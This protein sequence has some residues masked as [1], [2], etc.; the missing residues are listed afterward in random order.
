M[1]P[2]VP[3]PDWR[4]RPGDPIES[5]E[6]GHAPW[7]DD[8]RRTSVPAA[9]GSR[10]C[11]DSG[12]SGGATSSASRPG[13]RPGPPDGALGAWPADVWLHLDLDAFFA[14]VEEL[15]DPSLRGKPVVVGGRL[16]PDGTAGRGV[17]ST[18]NYAAREFGVGS[19]MPLAEAL[20]R[21]PH[22]VFLRGRFDR[23]REL[24]SRVM[25]VA[26]RF[27]PDMRRAGIDEAYLR[28]TGLRCWT[29]LRCSGDDEAADGRA[30][31]GALARRL[32]R[33]VRE[34][35]GLSCSVGVGPNR[36]L[37]KIASDYRKPGGVTVV[38]AD[39]AADFAS[40]L[41]LRSLRGVGPKSAERLRL[42]GFRTG[43]DLVGA[44]RSVV[45][46]LLGDHGGALW[47]AAHG[48]P[49]AG[50]GAR[51][52]GR[53]SLSHETTFP[54]DVTDRRALERALAR[55]AERAA[56]R[57]RREG[58]RAGC[59]GVKVRDADFTTRQRDR[60]MSD[61]RAGAVGF[62]SDERDIAPVALE[63]FGELLGHAGARTRPI[64]LV[65]VRLSRLSGIG[66]RQLRLGEGEASARADR[67]NAVAD[68]IRA[69]H[70]FDAVT[71]GAAARPV[72]SRP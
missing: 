65:G 33:E 54:E 40:G 64:R 4:T 3:Q 30:W 52:D 38:P 62:T 2:R 20:R 27:T 21:C 35:T 51:D 19:A 50:D 66:G 16:R 26:A 60:S 6:E 46:E 10:A 63:L 72:P 59:V 1:T 68:A 23:Y 45:V 13:A 8:A 36:F 71:S 44:D 70:G 12:A 22:A 49:R 56:W 53:R 57:L 9:A 14:Q 61:P 31:P 15:D 29:G 5:P 43:A 34:A 39:G 67:V 25:E 18:A 11:A 32:Q 37:A 55:L 47:D 69:R 48:L 58:L 41:P 7:A 17:V 24:S 28:L 42:R